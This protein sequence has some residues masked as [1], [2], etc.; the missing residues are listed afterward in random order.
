M[1]AKIQIFFIIMVFLGVF[2]D[3]RY[4]WYI[5]VSYLSK[6]LFFFGL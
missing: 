4:T 2:S 1:N 5:L 6:F 3:S